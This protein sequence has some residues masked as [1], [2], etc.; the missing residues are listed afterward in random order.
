MKRHPKTWILIADG[1][2]ARIVDYHGP[3]HPPTAV[4]GHEY[5]GDHSATGEMMSDAAGRT[6]NSVGPGRSAIEG[7]TDPHRELKV[8]FA[9]RLADILGL[10]LAKGAFDRLVIVAAPVTLGDLRPMLSEQVRATI[11][12]EVAADLTKIPNN[13]VIS[14]L[15]QIVLA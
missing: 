4:D 7:R 1:A 11:V 5:G 13:Q 6:H 12:G 2:R 10:E 14:H 3:D 8:E 15:G 9:R